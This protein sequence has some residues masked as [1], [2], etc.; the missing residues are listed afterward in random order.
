[1]LDPDPVDGRVA[2]RAADAVDL[3]AVVALL[4]VAEDREVRQVHVGARRWARS[5]RRSR[6]RS[7]VIVECH[8]P[9]PLMVTLLQRS[10]WPGILNVPSGIQTVPPAPAAVIAELNA[11][12]ESAAPVGSA[13]LLV[14]E[15][16]PAGWASGAGHVLEVGEVD[17]VRRGGVLGVDLQPELRAGRVGGREQPVHLVVEVVRVAA[18]RVGERVAAV[19]P[20]VR[21]GQRE[22]GLTWSR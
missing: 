6:A 19:V 10:M 16:E 21:V 4:D 18:R 5:C 13:P 17:R 9:A 22:V 3:V 8:M 7:P 12:V 15:T 14:T 11:A 1:M 2:Q 20:A